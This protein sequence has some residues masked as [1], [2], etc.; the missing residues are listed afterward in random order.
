MARGVVPLAMAEGLGQRPWSGL[1]GRVV[2]A[3]DRFSAEGTPLAQGVR[4]LVAPH[5]QALGGRLL[6]QAPAFPQ[7]L[8]IS[9]RGGTVVDLQGVEVLRGVARSTVTLTGNLMADLAAVIATGVTYE[10]AIE[11][12]VE[13]LGEQL[14]RCV[15]DTLDVTWTPSPPPAVC[16]LPTSLLALVSAA[17]RVARSPQLVAQEFRLALTERVERCGPTHLHGLD[18]IADRTLHLIRGDT[19]LEELILRS[20]R[21]REERTQDAWRAFDLLFHV[22]LICFPDGLRIYAGASAFPELGDLIPRPPE[23]LPEHEDTEDDPT[24][25]RP[26][27]T[28]AEAIT[29][30]D[31]SPPDFSTYDQDDL[32]ERPTDP[33][34]LTSEPVEFHEPEWMEVAQHTGSWTS[35]SPGSEQ[36]PLTALERLHRLSQRLPGAN[37]LAVLAMPLHRA[38][39]LDELGDAYDHRILEFH[40]TR[41]A[42]AGAEASALARTCRHALRSA[43]RALH[44]DDV[45]L[46]HHM[47]RLAASP[48]SDPYDL[49]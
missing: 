22:G 24:V 35:S 49:S 30:V 7:G 44:S 5:W 47:A 31:W 28:D 15:V 37:P 48:P 39:T 21:G 27:L 9:V 42:A 46:E 19:T 36:L 1:G 40:E 45:I 4:T 11:H 26:G 18:G 25:P 33:G 17:L 32:E 2:H 29:E 12:A 20:G 43:L 3:A 38:P 16:P 6:L 14:G 8:T 10:N 34:V 41:W 23:A 13:Q